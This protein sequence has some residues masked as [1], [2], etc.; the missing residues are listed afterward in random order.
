MPVRLPAE[1][2]PQSAVMLTWPHAGSDW[3]DLTAVF[4]AFAALGAAISADQELLSVGADA[5]HLAQIQDHLLST[6]AKPSRLRYASAASDDAW[7]RDHGPLTVLGDNGPVLNDFTFNG[8]GGK[9]PAGRDNAITRS[10]QAQGVFGDVPRHDPQL[11]L[12]GGAIE[13]DGQG[14]ILATRSSIIDASRNPGMG[15]AEL[16]QRLAGILGCRRFLWLDHG[17]LTGDDTDGHIDTL[18]RFADPGTLVHTTVPDNHPDHAAVAAMTD[19]LRALRTADGRPY[20]LI[21]LP[22]PGDHR[23]AD[24]RR[25]PATYANFLITNRSVLMPRYGSSADAAAQARLGTA[26]PGRRIVSIDCRAIIEQNGSL[27]CLTMQFPAALQLHAPH[28]IDRP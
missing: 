20:R 25:L 18:V 11:V 2:E 3:E 8:W 16:E 5:S 19:E 22:Y 10:L 26:F 24:G 23:G 7:A 15:V 28:T 27:H 1:W 17:A 6:G 13:T 21:P 4:E 12:E 9:Y 14:T